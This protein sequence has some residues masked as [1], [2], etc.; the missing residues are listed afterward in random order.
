MSM[1]D[2]TI[3]IFFLTQLSNTIIF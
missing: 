2:Y 3:L 1:I